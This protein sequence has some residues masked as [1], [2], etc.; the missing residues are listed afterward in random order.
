[1]LRK[2]KILKKM[3]RSYLGYKLGHPKPFICVYYTTF[4]CNL[5]CPYC[6]IVTLPPVNEDYQEVKRTRKSGLELSTE[7]AKYL[8]DQIA[9][10]GVSLFVFSGGEPLL[11]KDLEELAAYVQKKDMLTVL[12]TNGT[13]ITEERAK[14]IGKCFDTIAVSL[15]EVKEQNNKIREKEDLKKIKEGLRF[16]K[17]YST[18]KVGV[19]F[20]MNKFNYQEIEEVLNFAKE[21]CDFISY[22]AVH[23][24]PDFLLDKEIAKRVGKQLLELKR[25]HKDFISDTKEYLSLFSGHLGGE[26][27]SFKC[28]AFDLYVS[29][30][31]NG[32]FCGCC[33]PFSIGNILEQEAVELL[34]AGK[35]RKAELRKRCGCGILAGCGQ[36][37][38][39]F[40]Q[41]LLKSIFQGFSFL[42][43]TL[44]K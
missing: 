1:M 40:E 6:P 15:P 39:L 26:S 32:E 38:V 22:L 20:V 43:K 19:N 9:K 23:Y 18:A 3:A 14:L 41:P 11:R 25:K 29:I 35:S 42:K 37:S 5:S 21:N 28:N 7:K 4:R 34:K 30:G 27:I 16:L 10:L 44:F 13:L 33:Y 2:I 24:A 31:P 36:L 8:I 17:K 12:Y